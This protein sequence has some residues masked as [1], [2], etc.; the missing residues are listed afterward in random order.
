TLIS[1]FSVFCCG[2][3]EYEKNILAFFYNILAAI[4]QIATIFLIVGWIWSIRWGLIFIQLAESKNPHTQTTPFYVRRQS[5]VD[6][7][8]HQPF[9]TG[10]IIPRVP[11][12]LE[13]SNELEAV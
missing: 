13:D 6:T 11:P 1:S 3:H 4:L 10:M 2:K 9:L 7:P 8:M 12:V 5:S